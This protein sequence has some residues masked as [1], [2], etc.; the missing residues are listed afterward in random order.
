MV[1]S[2]NGRT[3]PFKNKV[4]V[5]HKHGQELLGLQSK[6]VWMKTLPK[7]YMV[8]KVYFNGKYFNHFYTRIQCVSMFISSIVKLF[9][10]FQ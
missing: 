1:N 2:K 6:E 5:N 3:M 9:R 4:R 8:D 10:L 7:C